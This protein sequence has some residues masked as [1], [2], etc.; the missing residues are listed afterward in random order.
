MVL[1]GVVRVLFGRVCLGVALSIVESAPPR[2]GGPDL[3]SSL[4]EDG[5]MD[6][7]RGWVRDHIVDV[8]AVVSLLIV[9]GMWYLERVLED[10]LAG[11]RSIILDL[12]LA[13]LAG[14]LFHLLVVVLPERRR[15]RRLFA[16]IGYDLMV[17]ADSGRAIVH[18]LEFVGECPE[19]EVATA[20]H[21]HLVCVANNR[22]DET[23]EVIAEMAAR[24]RQSFALVEPLLVSLPSEVAVR[25]V[26][27]ERLAR[28]FSSSPAPTEGWILPLEDAR[29]PGPLYVPGPDGTMVARRHT[30]RGPDEQD[31]WRYYVASEDLRA[32][33]VKE[34]PPAASMVTGT[35]LRMLTDANYEAPTEYP[36][37]ARDD[38]LPDDWLSSTGA[39]SG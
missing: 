30:L 8:L 3:R 14:W 23:M 19:P 12:A 11:T 16:T 20:E 15:Q 2:F 29:H 25:V 17:I 26:A 21:V 22:N 38:S 28:S 35:R 7:L 36:V 24:A 9:A 5:G 32:L 39:L 33:L 34:Y 6:R 18:A 4:R 13:Y 1:V 37:R 27:V 31:I 10:D